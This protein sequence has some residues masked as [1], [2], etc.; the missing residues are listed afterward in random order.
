MIDVDMNSSEKT[1]QIILYTKPITHICD[2][3][4]N[5]NRCWTCVNHAI[6]AVDERKKK[7][8]LDKNV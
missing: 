4:T 6:D 3:R 2:Y 1:T 7:S 8:T 5:V